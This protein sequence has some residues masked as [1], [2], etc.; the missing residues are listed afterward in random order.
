MLKWC[1]LKRYVRT[2]GIVEYQE[3]IP[4]FPTVDHD[5]VEWSSDVVCRLGVAQSSSTGTI[6]WGVKL[7]LSLIRFSHLVVYPVFCACI[8]ILFYKYWGSW[9]LL[10]LWF[11]WNWKRRDHHP[12][13]G[14]CTNYDRLKRRPK[15]WENQYYLTSL[16]KLLN[17]HTR[18]SHSSR[19]ARYVP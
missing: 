14:S 16:V 4:C 17:L 5:G 1:V 19:L 8:H 3:S 2:R 13:I 12:W 7:Y 15:K 9:F 10:F 11:R 6:N 18:S